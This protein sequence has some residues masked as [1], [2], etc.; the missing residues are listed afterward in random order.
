MLKISKILKAWNDD[1]EYF[2]F[3]Q[4]ER[5]AYYGGEEFANPGSALRA[6]KREFPCPTC[7]KPNKLTA[8]DI[9]LGYQCDICADADEGGYG[10]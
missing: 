1:E 6:G 4:E 7:K 5:N 9:K 8:K 3:E 10:Y 2:N